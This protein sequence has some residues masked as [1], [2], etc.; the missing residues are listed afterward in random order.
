MEAGK[1]ASQRLRNAKPDAL[2]IGETQ[3]KPMLVTMDI[4]ESLMIQT[5]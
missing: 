1:L 2:K 4:T 5:A 3:V